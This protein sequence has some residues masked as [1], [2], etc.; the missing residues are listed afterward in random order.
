MTCGADDVD[1]KQLAGVALDDCFTA[2]DRSSEAAVVTFSP[3][4]NSRPLTLTL[5]RSFTH[6][7]CFTG[8]TLQPPR[9]RRALALEPMTCPPNALSTGDGIVTIEP[10]G[11]FGDEFVL[12]LG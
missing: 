5:G 11:T 7:M 6:L 10:G 9:H 4:P 8:D 1:A 3:G 2:I 12:T